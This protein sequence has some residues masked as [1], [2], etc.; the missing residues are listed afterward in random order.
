MGRETCRVIYQIMS[1]AKLLFFDKLENWPASSARFSFNWSSAMI[2]WN[3]KTSIV[4]NCLLAT[5]SSLRTIRSTPKHK[6]CGESSKAYRINKEIVLYLFLQLISDNYDSD[7]N[8]RQYRSA[9][10]RFTAH[11]YF[12][13][14]WA[15]KLR[16]NGLITADYW[17]SSEISPTDVSSK[18]E[19]RIWNGNCYAIGSHF[20]VNWLQCVFFSELLFIV[21]SNPCETYFNDRDDIFSTQFFNDALDFSTLPA[22]R[23]L[24]FIQFPA[25]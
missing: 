2:T 18:K 7:S 13:R 22:R 19:S 9:L 14:G 11:E 12:H 5:R 23:F 8:W 4:I 20:D 3:C 17:F 6:Q 25:K 16:P 10:F 21:S 1:T 24:Q 15:R